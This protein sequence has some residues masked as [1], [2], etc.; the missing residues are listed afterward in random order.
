MVEVNTEMLSALLVTIISLET[1]NEKW[2]QLQHRH[3]RNYRK[4]R[5]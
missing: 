5:W 1:D 4:Y 2:R 3:V